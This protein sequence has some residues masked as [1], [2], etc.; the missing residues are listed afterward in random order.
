MLNVADRLCGDHIDKV[1]DIADRPNHVETD[2]E[3]RT[4]VSL[5]S[6]YM[7]RNESEAR[8]RKTCTQFIEQRGD[9]GLVI[10]YGPGTTFGL[11]AIEHSS[12]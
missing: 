11:V 4:D 10:A 12:K 9:D 6:A 3:F 1:L 2:A 8:R 7:G 5:A